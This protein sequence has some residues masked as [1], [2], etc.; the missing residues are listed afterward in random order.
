[1]KKA[2]PKKRGGKREGA[3]RK[4]SGRDPARTF[5]LS[6][7]LIAAVDGWAQGNDATRSEAIRRLVELGLKAKK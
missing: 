6:D 5:R 3:G 7:E 2:I 4:P 1:M